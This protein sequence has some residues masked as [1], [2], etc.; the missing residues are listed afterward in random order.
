MAW[1]PPGDTLIFSYK[2]RLVPFLG[3]QNTE[4]QYGGGGG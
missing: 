4:F 1:Y 3:V 2:R